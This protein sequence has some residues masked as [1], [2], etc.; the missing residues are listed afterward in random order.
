MSAALLSATAG[1]AL[2]L[3]FDPVGAS[4]LAPV[5]IGAFTVAVCLFADTARGG[6]VL[7]YLFGFD[8]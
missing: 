6:A 7:G 1:G 3:A 5:A 4:L 8:L 2:A